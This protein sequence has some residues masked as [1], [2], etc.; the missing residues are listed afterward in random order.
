MQSTKYILLLCSLFLFWNCEENDYVQP[1]ELPALTQEG[2]QTF[3]A[4]INGVKWMP[5][6]RYSSNTNFHVPTALWGKY[7]AQTLRIAVS[8]QET[9]ETMSFMVTSIKGEGSYRFLTY[10]PKHTSGSEFTPY[11]SVYQKCKGGNCEQ[12]VIHPSM[13]NSLTITHFDSLQKIYAGRF[14]VSFVNKRN[15]ADIITVRDGRFDIKE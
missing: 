6:Q 13:E 3:G 2:K 4:E 5:F 9:L 8:N 15:P 14:T 7:T 12:Y 11:A 10:Y 1:A